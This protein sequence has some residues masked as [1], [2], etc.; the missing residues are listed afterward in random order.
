M[1]HC[2]QAHRESLFLLKPGHSYQRKRPDL[3]HQHSS[4]LLFG[5]LLVLILLML[6]QTSLMLHSYSCA[7][8]D[9]H[10]DSVLTKDKVIQMHE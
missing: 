1:L 3:A 9:S 2:M 5:H 4:A 10:L 6:L 7:I 8:C